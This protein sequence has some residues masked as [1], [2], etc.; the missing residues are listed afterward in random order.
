MTTTGLKQLIKECIV[1]VLTEDLSEGFDPL[2]WGPN[3]PQEN[4][5]PAWNAKMRTME[6]DKS[7]S[8]P[9]TPQ[10]Q[11]D[12]FDEFRKE[13]GTDRVNEFLSK[14]GLGPNYIPKKPKTYTCPKCKGQNAT[15]AEEGAD[16]DGGQ[17]EVVLN[18]PDC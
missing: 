16:C 13:M 2:S 7:D 12:G 17:N 5:Y 4:P 11:G 1:E 6:E 14:F 18:C 9:H 8:R 15:Y 3:N 10:T